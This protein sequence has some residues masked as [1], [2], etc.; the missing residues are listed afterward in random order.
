MMKALITG[1]SSGIGYELARIMAE[2]GHDLVLVARDLPA[3]KKVK[4][5]LESRFGVS[6]V[7]AAKDLS[8]HGAVEELYNE[9]RHERIEILV[10]NAGVGLR[11]NFFDDD[12]SAN[13]AMAYLNMNAL[14]EMTHYFGG[15]LVKK[16]A[17][18]ILNIGSIVAF[19]PGPKQ[20]VYYATKSFVR[21]FSRSL[22]YNLRDTNVTLTV[23]HPGITKTGFFKAA[24]VKS[25]LGG[26]SPHD[27]AMTGY[28]AMMTGKIEV[29]HGFKNKLLTNVFVRL[30]PYRLHALI[31]DKAADA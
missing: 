15:D 20:P 9:L 28:D 7:V 12:L 29:T 13:Q 18:K 1:A 17:G 25:D 26:A 10:N 22:A 6:V 5:E 24:H 19:V 31:V 14:M 21:S 30:F 3:L 16:N 11:G 8:V 23:L 27:V 4:K 2:K